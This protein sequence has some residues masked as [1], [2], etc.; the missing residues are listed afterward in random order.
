MEIYFLTVLEAV[1][2]R[3]KSQGLCRSSLWWEPSARLADGP[4]L[5]VS[6]CGL[7]LVP[8]HRERERGRGREG[9]RGNSLVSLCARMLILSSQ[10]PTLRASFDLR[11]LLTG[12]VSQCRNI[13]GLV[14]NMGI[15]WSGGTN[16]QFIT[17]STGIAYFHPVTRLGS[18]I[19]CFC[20]TRDISLLYNSYRT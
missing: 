10:G 12:A 1:E 20:D 3:S 8:V 6:S 7:S 16:I 19:A 11:S 15:W 9:G 13:G 5:T 17:L 14:F 2:L 4:P 18:P